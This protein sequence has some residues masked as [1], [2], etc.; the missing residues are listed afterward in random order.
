MQAPA[1]APS[2]PPSRRE[3]PAPHLRS[4]ALLRGGRRAYIE[5]RGELY[6]L[7]LTRQ[8]RLILTK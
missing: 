8:G 1:R 5:H 6:R 4:T 7:D 3:Q 2:P